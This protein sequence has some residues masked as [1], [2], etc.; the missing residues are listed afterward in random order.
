MSDPFGPMATPISAKHD[1]RENDAGICQIAGQARYDCRNHQ[2]QR[3]YA[4]EL[5]KQHCQCRARRS[6][7]QTV[8]TRCHVS[9]RRLRLAEPGLALHIQTGEQLLWQEDVGDLGQISPWLLHS[10]SCISGVTR[11]IMV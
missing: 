11:A 4:A 10:V 3:E 7:A 9:A 2:N 8:F 1:N 5:G 6:L